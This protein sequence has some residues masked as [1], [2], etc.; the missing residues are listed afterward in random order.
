MQDEKP[1]ELPGTNQG[2]YE[3]RINKLQTISKNKNQEFYGAIS[4]FKKRHQPGINTVKDEN[5]DQLADSHDISNRYKNYFCQILNV[6][7]M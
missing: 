2:M 7:R 6:Y 1:V 5:D 4:T 3:R